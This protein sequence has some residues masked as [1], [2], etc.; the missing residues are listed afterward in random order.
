MLSL[1]T[2]CCF[3]YKNK[4]DRQYKRPIRSQVNYM[5]EKMGEFFDS[6]LKLQHGIT[7]DE[8]YHYDTPLTIE[9]ETQAL[10]EATYTIK[11]MR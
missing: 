2:I 11:A 4:A 6:R 3:G 10:R 1:K 5:L 9:H 8:F 7:D